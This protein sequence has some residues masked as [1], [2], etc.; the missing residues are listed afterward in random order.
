MSIARQALLAGAL[1]VWAPLGCDPTK[2]CDT[3]P[4]VLPH[5][6]PFRLCE[7]P[8]RLA[9]ECSE[10]EDCPTRDYLCEDGQCIAE[11]SYNLI[12][13]NNGCNDL[14]IES[15]ELRGDDRCSYGEVSVESKTVEPSGFAF[16]S[17]TYSPKSAGEDQVAL[18]IRSNAVNFPQLIIPVCGVGYDQGKLD[19]PCED[20]LACGQGLICRPA[21]VTNDLRFCDGSQSEDIAC[22]CRPF[23]PTCQVPAEPE[24]NE[25]CGG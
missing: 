22:A 20:S 25:Q 16:V 14:V 9:D 1:T 4:T 7:Q 17:F 2:P 6:S 23:C 5:L 24:V 11:K 18:Y 10:A 19:Q 12:L 8:L 15:V 13:S 3:A 21:D